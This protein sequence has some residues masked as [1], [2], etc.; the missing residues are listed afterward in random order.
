MRA[1]FFTLILIGMIS[2]T[3]KAQESQV[4]LEKQEKKDLL[5][6]EF[7]EDQVPDV[8]IDGKK[9]D[10]EILRLLDQD[11]IETLNVVKGERAIK[12]FNAPNGVL[13]ITTVKPEKPKSQVKVK[14]IVK[15]VEGDPGKE[16]VVIIDGKISSQ[17]ELSQIS[18]ESIESIQVF[19]GQKA[20]ELYNAPYGAVVV[21][22]KK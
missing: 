17:K 4:P 8:Y 20:M 19:K 22:T 10:Y 21:K 2:I 12:E 15:D 3:L 5:E 1:T 14:K 11:K 13:Q 7:K 18:P 16:P 6:F 9:Y